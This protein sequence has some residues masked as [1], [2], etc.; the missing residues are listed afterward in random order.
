MYEPTPPAT[1]PP[2]GPNLLMHLFEYPDHAEVTPVLYKRIP[3]KLRAKLEAC[4]IQGSSAGW[5]IHYVEGLD[6]LTMY[7]Y[8]CVGFAIALVMAV[9]WASIRDDVQG[10]FAIAGF[11][12]AFLAFCGSLVQSEFG[13][14]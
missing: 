12:I 10:G 4:P 13:G 5:G 1:N 6:R 9:I 8:G 7:I 14:F 11:L 2:I 3:R